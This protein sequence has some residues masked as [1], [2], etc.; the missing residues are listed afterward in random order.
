MIFLLYQCLLDKCSGGCAD[1]FNKTF[2]CDSCIVYLF[3]RKS[4]GSGKVETVANANG[5]PLY[6]NPFCVN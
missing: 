6:D 3:L 1:S 4:Q 5:M 2:F